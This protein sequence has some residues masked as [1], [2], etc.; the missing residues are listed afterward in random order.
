MEYDVTKSPGLGAFFAGQRRAE[1]REKVLSDL[2]TQELARRSML[3]KLF[4]GEQTFPLELERQRL[5]NQATEAGIE[6]TRGR[7]TDEERK[8]RMEATDK[9]FDYMQKY[10][11]PQGALEY[12]GV[13]P[14]FA[15]KFMQMTP[16][17]RE[18]VYEQ[19]TKRGMRGEEMKQEMLS[20]NRMK[21]TEAAKTLELSKAKMQE[22]ERTKRALEV[23][24]LNAEAR[25]R[26][27]A[28]KAKQIKNQSYQ[29][30]A[31]QLMQ[32][33]MEAKRMP[34]DTME[35]K[36]AKTQLLSELAQQL[37]VVV[38]QDLQHQA[39]ATMQRQG[40]QPDIGSLSG[41]KIPT[42]PQPQPVLPGQQLS[43]QQPAP[44]KY[45]V[46]QVYKGKTGLYRY[47]GKNPGNLKDMSNWEK[48]Q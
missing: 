25:V 39:F 27:S 44:Q 48:V 9:F 21:E 11:D 37:D 2:A 7:I 4:Q 26:A 19:W 34:E 17:Q 24:R 32:Q 14:R 5:T 41:G 10:D 40:G 42:I 30:Y 29:Q 1:E 45:V 15:Q 36:Q 12:S 35:Q 20:K 6:Q 28:E 47:T 3:Q 13:P 38:Q 8:R 43:E 23:A 22:E 31:T 18:K 16:E 46:G 33:M